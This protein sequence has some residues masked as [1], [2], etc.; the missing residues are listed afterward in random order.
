MFFAHLFPYDKYLAGGKFVLSKESVRVEDLGEDIIVAMFRSNVCECFTLNDAMK[1][2][3]TGMS[4]GEFVKVDHAN[5]RL[6]GA[7]HFMV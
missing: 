3:D 6:W 2:N 1:V 7:G 4:G 5:G